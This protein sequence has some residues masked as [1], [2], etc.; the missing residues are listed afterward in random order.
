M[1]RDK[2]QDTRQDRL[3]RRLDVLLRVDSFMSTLIDL[4]QLLEQIMQ[5]SQSVTDAAASSLALLDEKTREFVFH[6]VLGE[7]GDAAKKIRIGYSEGII[8]HVAQTGV[9]Q[10]IRD[11]YTD[12]R[13]CP[14]VDRSTGFTT[15]SLLAVPLV[16]RGRLIGV[17]EVLN[18]NSGAFFSDDDQ[19]ILETLAHQAAIAIEN[20][21]LYQDSLAKE[22]LASLGQGISGAAHCIKNILNVITLGADG[23]DLGLTRGNIELVKD[24]WTPLQKGCQRITELVMDMLSY[25]KDRVPEM[26]AVPVNELL[27]DI[28]ALITPRCREQHVA[29]RHSLDP[30]TGTLMLD[31]NGIHRC[32]MNLISNAIDAL[33]KKGGT[34]TV[35]SRLDTGTREAVLLVA[36]DGPGIPRENL[37]KIFEVFYS[38]KGSQGTGLGLA[39]TRK[40]ITEHGGTITAASEPSIGAAFTIRLPA[41]NG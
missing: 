38:T 37:Q 13:F 30:A 12:P 23:I 28:I 1:Q 31:K 25:A 10:N 40:I 24:S 9:S 7:K 2:V 14:R 19:T 16:R 11:A 35:E 4:D 18:K 15:R 41:G 21:R 34:I 32:L 17:I 3:Q 6:V 20:A 27:L 5:E 33:G 22:R 29:L 26:T 39:I 8:G 36:D